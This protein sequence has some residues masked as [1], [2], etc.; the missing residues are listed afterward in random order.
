MENFVEC[1]SKLAKIL[2]KILS[3]SFVHFQEFHSGIYLEKFRL[4]RE[5]SR[6]LDIEMMNF[7]LTD[8][9]F[10]FHEKFIFSGWD[11]KVGMNKAG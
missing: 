9:F 3:V 5:L 8:L 1:T 6:E 4:I 2:N 7:H 11:E 10:Q